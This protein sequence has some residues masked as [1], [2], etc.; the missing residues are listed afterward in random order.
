VP[1]QANAEIGQRYL[2]QRWLGDGAHGV[3]WR[4]WDGVRGGP[5][6]L[7][8]YTTEEGTDVQAAEAA[9]QFQV[10]EGDAVLPLLEVHPTFLE[11]PTTA[12]PEM[13]GTYAETR[14]IFVS[15]AVYATRRILT[16]LEFCHGR[17]VV[18]GDIKPSNI[19]RDGR[20]HVRLGDFGVAGTTPEYIAPELVGGGERSVATDLWAVAVSFYELVCGQLPFGERP[21]D[22]EQE[23]AARI[24]AGAHPHPDTVLPYLPQSFRGFFRRAFEIDPTKRAW[25]KAGAMRGAL[26]DLSS[27]VEWVRFRR[28]DCELCFEGHELTPDAHRT[29]VTY[30]ATV[31][32]RPRKIEYVPIIKKAA[33]TGQTPRRL[34]GLPNYAGSKAQA[35]Q[36]LRVWMRRLTDSGDWRG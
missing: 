20:G 24:S 13:A 36:K 22:D 7:K 19:F 30:E 3:V 28:D 27:C 17:G 5:V 29:G 14:P 32:Y 1:L 16:A 12:M 6:A 21:E 2:F 18:H 26:G 25:T 35:A 9:R 4:A 23:I 11:G 10:A 15:Q 34:T 8:I 31:T 33:A